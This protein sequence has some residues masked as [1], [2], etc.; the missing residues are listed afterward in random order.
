M[1][2]GLD[3]LP[4]RRRIIPVLSGPLTVVAVNHADPGLSGWEQFGIAVGAVLVA[5]V[6]TETVRLLWRHKHR[7]ELALQCGN[8]PRF[9]KEVNANHAEVGANAHPDKGTPVAVFSKLIRVQETRGYQAK[10]VSVRVLDVQPPPDEQVEFPVVA[11]WHETGNSTVTDS[12][13][14]GPRG[15]RDLIFQMILVW[16]PP[17]TFFL[18]TP[19]GHQPPREVTYEIHV[20]GKH[21]K[22]ETLS[23]TAGWP[24]PELRNP[25]P[26]HD[27]T[28]LEKFPFP[29][30]KKAL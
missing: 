27:F 22:T 2:G 17:W 13:D 21:H 19:F 23:I 28:D 8:G 24:V 9:D 16:G 14:I 10:N 20:D 1:H 7:P 6:L 25:D 29:K 11:H 26:A 4:S 3:L 12:A 5:T 18:V 15:H 30:V